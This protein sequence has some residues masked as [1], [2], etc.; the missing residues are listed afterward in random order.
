[1]SHI[2]Q[3]SYREGGKVKQEKLAATCHTIRI[4]ST[5]TNTNTNTNTTITKHSEPPPLQ[6]KALKPLGLANK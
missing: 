1:M 5:N 2:L 4:A 3:R 6:T